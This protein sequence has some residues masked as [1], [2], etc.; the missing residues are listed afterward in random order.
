MCIVRFLVRLSA[1]DWGEAMP[2]PSRDR[3]EIV[4]VPYG[5]QMEPVWLPYGGRAEMVRYLQAECRVFLGI[6]VPK[7]YSFTSLLVVSFEMATKNKRWEGKAPKTKGG[8]GNLE[9]VGL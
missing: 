7:V 4:Q 2:R 3:T 5:N 6:L 1:T 9:N 8:K